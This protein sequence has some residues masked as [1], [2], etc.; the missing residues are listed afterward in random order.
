MI[1]LLLLVSLC[2]ILAAPRP[3]DANSVDVT[4]GPSIRWEEYPA[5][6]IF[7]GPGRLVL[8]PGDRAYRTRLREAARRA[9]DFAGHYVMALWGCGMECLMG[10]AIDRRSG[11]VIWLPGTLCCWY[12]GAQEAANGI[13]PVRYRL[14]SRLLVLNGMRDEREGDLGTHLYRIEGG[15]FVHLADLTP[16]AVVAAPPP[17][18][19]TE[20]AP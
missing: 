10:A 2:A 12:S 13:E 14:D 17:D 6:R 19:G 7:G 3:S 15:R 1:R 20:A 16:D 5:G 9:P 11:R 8:R 4:P 18:H